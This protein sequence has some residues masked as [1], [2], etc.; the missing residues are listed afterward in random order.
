[1]FGK[2]ILNDVV[3]LDDLIP[4][5]YQKIIE[6][7]IYFHT[8]FT[9][10]N[11]FKGTSYIGNDE[12]LQKDSSKMIFEQFQLANSTT[13]RDKANPDKDN[14]QKKLHFFEKLN[15]QHYFLTPLQF[16]LAKLNYMVQFENII[17]IKSNFQTRAF[18]KTP[19]QY[20]F[21]HIDIDLN[22][23]EPNLACVAIYYVNDSDGDTV[24]F[25][26]ES[27]TPIDQLTI[28]QR[29]ASKKGRLV[30][31]PSRFLHAGSHPI[32]SPYRFVINYNF[33][34]SRT[35]LDNGDFAKIKENLLG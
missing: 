16:G 15:W 17:R 8:P 33:Y 13:H 27:G 12:L 7:T 5:Y 4:T 9:M 26:E 32:D 21:P 14:P 20:N 11:T 30:I 22:I 35:M 25:N 1:M 31:M 24:I 18:N 28:K 2:D 10:G 23:P 19:D 3:V 6:E 29:V 34:P